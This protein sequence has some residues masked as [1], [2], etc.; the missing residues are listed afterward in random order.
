MAQRQPTISQFAEAGEDVA[1][2]RCPRGLKQMMDRK[3]NW[4]I[5]LRQPDLA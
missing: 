5:E 4:R 1:Y 3:C 2:V